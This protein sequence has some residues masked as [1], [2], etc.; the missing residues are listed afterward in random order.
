MLKPLYITFDMHN[1]MNENHVCI[2]LGEKTKGMID[3]YAS[4]NEIS[5]S[6]VIRLAVHKFLKTGGTS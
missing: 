4:D 5:R 2:Y 1:T 3:K 6:S